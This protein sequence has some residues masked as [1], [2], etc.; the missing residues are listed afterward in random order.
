MSVDRKTLKSGADVPTV[1][2][3]ACAPKVIWG[4]PLHMAAEM[5]NASVSTVS[6]IFHSCTLTINLTQE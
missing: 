2:G 4:V 1:F 3:C 5:P 6:H